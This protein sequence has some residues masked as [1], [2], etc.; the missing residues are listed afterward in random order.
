M[1]I[2]ESTVFR[3]RVGDL[4][5]Q[6]RCDK[7]EAFDEILK[8]LESSGDLCLEDALVVKGYFGDLLLHC[9][10]LLIPRDKSRGKCLLSE[11]SVLEEYDD[12][13]CSHLQYLFGIYYMEC[14]T[15]MEREMIELMHKAA[16]QGHVRS[17]DALGYCYGNALA[18]KKDVNKAF[19]Y[20]HVAATKGN[21]IAQFNLGVCYKLGSGCTKN[22]SL[23]FEWFQKSAD[24]SYLEAVFEMGCCY[25][26]AYG[27]A[28][29]FVKA[30]HCFAIAAD[31]EH[32]IAVFRLAWCYLS[33]R[34][35]VKDERKAAHLCALAAKKGLV[36]ATQLLGQ[37]NERGLGME[38]NIVEAVRNY[39]KAIYLAA[40]K[41]CTEDIALSIRQ[42]SNL[43]D[44][45]KE[46]VS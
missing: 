19:T 30:A 1:E 42:V 33:G 25:R 41:G 6:C 35:V 24:Q 32:A 39:K 13:S 14:C 21:P 11:L 34:G 29:N 20:H 31:R 43:A 5:V 36:A 38:K 27:V 10:S 37:M 45:Y 8:M 15:G 46:T 12:L 18:V 3:D 7:K 16:D 22:S 9:D 28:L 26:F 23:A 17:I 4:Y 2:A 40:Q 44:V